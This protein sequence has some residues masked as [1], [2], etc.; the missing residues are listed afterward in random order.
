M[1][2][3]RQSHSFKDIPPVSHVQYTCTSSPWLD[4]EVRPYSP[5]ASQRF[6]GDDFLVVPV[7][8]T[9]GEVQGS[10]ESPQPPSTVHPEEEQ[11]MLKC[12][13]AA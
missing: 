7:P 2:A 12:T 8:M 1:Y 4:K 9:L 5:D 6:Q 11:T 10:S 13:W 3:T